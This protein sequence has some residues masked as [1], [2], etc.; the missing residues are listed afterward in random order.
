MIKV[1]SDE[2]NSEAHKK[3]YVTMKI[4][5]NHI[6]EIWKI[7]LEDI[8]YYKISNIEVYRYIFILID[9]FSK[10]LWCV[11]L[12]KSALTITN[13][14]F[15]ILSTCERSPL[16]LDGNQGA[17]CCTLN[18]QNFLKVKKIQHFSRFTENVPQ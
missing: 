7:D 8:I 5:Y 12:K 16:V 1:F 11:P 10:L 6:D 18:F 15:N 4:I 13:D 9:N 17:E 2:K 14:F 3:N